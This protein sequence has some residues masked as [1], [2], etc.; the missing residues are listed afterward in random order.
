MIEHILIG[1]FVIES[2]AIAIQLIQIYLNVE[3]DVNQ[4]AGDL[5]FNIPCQRNLKKSF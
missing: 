5:N 3:E 4:N 1:R 2:F